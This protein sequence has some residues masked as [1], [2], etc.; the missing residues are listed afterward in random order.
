MQRAAQHESCRAALPAD[1]KK[2]ER[3]RQCVVVYQAVPKIAAF[4]RH[5]IA[6]LSAPNFKHSNGVMALPLTKRHIGQ[7]NIEQD[8]HRRRPQD[9]QTNA[10][11]ERSFCRC[12]DTSP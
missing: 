5:A 12:H 1:S 4:I 6:R 3:Y 8:A 2:I 9:G 11:L 7:T 10:I